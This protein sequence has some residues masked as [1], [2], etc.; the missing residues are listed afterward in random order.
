MYP[1]ETVATLISELNGRIPP[2]VHTSGI[3]ESRPV[4]AVL[5][6]NVSLVKHNHHNSNYAGAKYDSN[7][8]QTAEIYRYYYALR[9]ELQVRAADEIEAY[10]HHGSLLDALTSIERRP[11][12]RL[13]EDVHEVRVGD[14]GPVSY[15]YFEP[16]ETEIN[17]SV[18][19]ET[20]FE[21]EEAVDN[22]IASIQKNLNFS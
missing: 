6:D 20:F 8:N 22:V 5:L 15:Q 9:A 14:S 4:P 17:Q 13:H 16:T 10:E 1:K 19:I 7:T 12:E 11:T 2:P 18:V 3:E 21:S